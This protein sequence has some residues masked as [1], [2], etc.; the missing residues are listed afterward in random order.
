MTGRMRS[1]EFTASTSV[2][3]LCP[4]FG[5]LKDFIFMRSALVYRL[6]L[7]SY[8]GMPFTFQLV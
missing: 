8:F 3:I 7:W 4:F 6:K 5:L 2:K 1:S